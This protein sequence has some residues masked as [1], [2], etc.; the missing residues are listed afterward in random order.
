[1]PGGFLEVIEL[2]PRV[3]RGLH[4]LGFVLAPAALASAWL[5]DPAT[6]PGALRT[7]LLLLG[8][9]GLGVAGWRRRRAWPRRAVL[10]PDG[11][12]RLGV[13]GVEMV[14]ARLTRCWGAGEGPLVALEWA[15]ADGV[16]R[17]AWVWRTD[18]DPR[19]WRR[20]RVRLRLA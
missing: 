11:Q 15:C 18:T 19:T 13:A 9:C 17:S 3:D 20:L 16:R 14:V 8:A 4:I 2:R 1:M 10:L 6:V 7:G 5:A 12:W